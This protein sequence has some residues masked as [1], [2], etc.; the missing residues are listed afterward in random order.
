MHG[1]SSNGF[2]YYFLL[3]VQFPINRQIKSKFHL[4]KY[5]YIAIPIFRI[6]CSQIELFYGNLAVRILYTF[7][8]VFYQ[9]P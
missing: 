2:A 7:K 1:L 6:C 5:Y 8:Y 3:I 9:K 4:R